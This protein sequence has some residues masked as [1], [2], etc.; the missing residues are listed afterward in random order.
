MGSTMKWSSLTLSV[1]TDW[2][3]F[4]QPQTTAPVSSACWIVIRISSSTEPS[5]YVSRHSSEL[6]NSA[7]LFHL[8]KKK[9]IFRNVMLLVGQYLWVWDPGLPSKFHLVPEM[10]SVLHF[11]WRRA[12]LKSISSISWWHRQ[13]PTPPCDISVLIYWSS[14]KWREMMQFVRYLQK[15][16]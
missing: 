8:R 13:D 5:L 1:L 12:F 6:F 14:S 3:W 7:M 15:N 4:E 2:R 16:A 10:K 9:K 11:N